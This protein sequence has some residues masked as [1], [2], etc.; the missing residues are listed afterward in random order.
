MVTFEDID[1]Q[2][3]PRYHLQA[4]HAVLETVPHAAAAH[5]AVY[6]QLNHGVRGT[7]LPHADATT[8][9]EHFAAVAR[10]REH[11]R[12]EQFEWHPEAGDV[13][14][15]DNRR[16][17]HGRGPLQETAEEGAP[18]RELEGAYMEWD[19][20]QSLRRLL[21]RQRQPPPAQRG[22]TTAS[23]ASS[24]GPPKTCSAEE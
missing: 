21:Q 23:G 3:P 12:A 15:F 10:F 8:A 16:V 17:L 22:A 13:W 1:P 5:G 14:V 7:A 9:R 2:V 6:V 19:D 4:R 24:D 11:L 18:R 20:L